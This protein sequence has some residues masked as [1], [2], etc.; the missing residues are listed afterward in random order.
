MLNIIFIYL[1]D[2]FNNFYNSSNY[3]LIFFKPASDI[4]INIL[5]LKFVFQLPSISNPLGFIQILFLILL[6]IGRLK[7]FKKLLYKAPPRQLI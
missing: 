4:F 6:N 1:T 5:V 3:D 7:L 2:K